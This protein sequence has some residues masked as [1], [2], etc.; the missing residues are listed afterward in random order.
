MRMEQSEELNEYDEC[1]LKASPDELIRM[2]VE[3]STIVL[4]AGLMRGGNLP[5]Y[6]CSEWQ[7]EEE[8]HH[9]LNKTLRKMSLSADDY[10]SLTIAE[11]K[12]CRIYHGRDA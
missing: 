3:G 11:K 2:G 9:S 6:L 4:F 10:A 12:W 5:K 1:I 8:N 7:R